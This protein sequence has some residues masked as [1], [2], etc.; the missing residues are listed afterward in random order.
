MSILQVLWPS[1]GYSNLTSQIR[2]SP[3]STGFFSEGSRDYWSAPD[4][5]VAPLF[6][7]Q[8]STEQSAKQEAL[9]SAKQ[10]ALEVIRRTPEQLG[11][12]Q[13]R[14]TLAA[15]RETLT[16]CRNLTLS[17]LHQL[18]DRLGIVW[19]RARNYVHSP[20]PF[21]QEKLAYIYHIRALVET[22][23]ERYAFL[24]QDEVSFE[25]QP[26]LASD[27]EEEGEPQP[28]ARLSHQSNTPG[29][30][31]GGLN[32]LTGQV[33][34]LL[35]SKVTLS[36][37]GQF[38]KAVCADYPWA[39]TIFIVQDNW[40]QHFHPDTLVRLQP[41]VLPWPPK[42]PP[43]FPKEPHPYI[44]RNNLPIRLLCL[45]TYA[46]WLNPIEKLW[47]WLRQTV[48]HLHRLSNDWSGLKQRV[49]D[50]LDQFRHGSQ[51]LLT[52]VG[53]RFTCPYAISPPFS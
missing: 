7:P 41:Q 29:R 4:G 51:S 18:L 31:I 6:P 16:W 40:P 36:K 27:W 48:L 28:L 10:K 35:V 34:Y 11:H 20:D 3:G 33:T 50:F 43:N 25:R 47:R 45:P 12:S 49:L 1:M 44:P 14:W 2:F 46:S 5:V 13:S 21:Y 39:E 52:Y 15:L 32:A 22:Y 24:Y 17:G 42:L 19:K 37:L 26:T 53:L 30:I 38:Y 9:Q 23:P 8:H